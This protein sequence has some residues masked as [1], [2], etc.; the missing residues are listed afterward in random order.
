MIILDL[1]RFVNKRNHSQLIVYVRPRN[2]SQHLHVSRCLYGET[3]LDYSDLKS[4]RKIL[5]V[6]AGYVVEG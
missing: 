5:P 3:V 1:L 4:Q 2:S 6:T